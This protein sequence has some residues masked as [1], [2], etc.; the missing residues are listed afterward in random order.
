MAADHQKLEPV[1]TSNSVA[2]TRPPH[3]HVDWSK[4]GLTPPRLQFLAEL[5]AEFIGIFLLIL[6]GD[7]CSSMALLFSP[8]PYLSAYWG[9]C[10]TWGLAVT[11]AIYGTGGVSGCHIN[12]AVTVSFAL[13]RGF[14]WWK[15]VPYTIAQ[16]L[17]AFVGA[18]SVYNMY[19]P[20]FTAY[21]D[22]NGITKQDSVSS[23]EAFFTSVNEH[24]TN[25]DGFIGQI[26]Q[27][28]ILVYGIFAV[29]DPFNPNSFSHNGLKALLIGYVVAMV[30]GG[31]GFLEGFAIN[32]AR[33]FG[34]RVAAYS[35]GWGKSAFPGFHNYW[36]GPICGPLIGGPLGAFIYEAFNRPF[37]PGVQIHG[38]TPF[39]KAWSRM[40]IWLF[41]KLA[42]Y[43]EHYSGTDK[44]NIT[45]E[46]RFHSDYHA[47]IDVG[48]GGTAP[49]E[50]GIEGLDKSL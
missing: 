36:W 47:M 32:P 23:S 3:L 26:Y 19:Y 42:V 41:P 11:F 2:P 16:F 5:M 35:L 29:T 31:F 44:A 21:L 24:L 4:I 38:D 22:T 40:V 12:P 25:Y 17:G 34:P 39:M 9:V 46:D 18:Y 33:D 30:G 43:H 6:V 14:P 1:N 45:V 8:S 48:P 28:G 10:I 20:I 49:Q 27:T 7:S 37:M 13:F 50:S 15:V